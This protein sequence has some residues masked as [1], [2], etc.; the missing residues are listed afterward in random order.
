MKKYIKEIIAAALILF[1]FIFKTIA[2]ISLPSNF[3]Y[4]VWFAWPIFEFLPLV[5]ALI[6][7]TYKYLSIQSIFK[8]LVIYTPFQFVYLFLYVEGGIPYLILQAVLPLLKVLVFFLIIKWI[9]KCRIK[10]GKV[11]LIIGASLYIAYFLIFLLSTCVD[12]LTSIS[13]AIDINRFYS[14]LSILVRTPSINKLTIPF[15][16]FHYAVVIAG[17]IGMSLSIPTPAKKIEADH[18]VEEI[19]EIEGKWRCMGCGEYVSNDKNRCECGY[20]R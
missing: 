16:Y 12:F 5:I 2:Y 6:T 4:K 3:G 8:A 10:I 15:Q 20:K 9:C 11:F 7:V 1:C 19:L 13:P 14:Y 18:E 17:V